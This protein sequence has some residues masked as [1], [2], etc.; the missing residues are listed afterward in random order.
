LLKN[1]PDDFWA[2]L[3]E[4]GLQQEYAAGET[5]VKAGDTT[6]DVYLILSGQLRVSRLSRGGREPNLADLG[7][8][9]IFGELAAIDGQP[10]SAMV[11]ALT[12]ATIVK[13]SANAFRDTLF[14]NNEWVW[15]LLK[16]LSARSRNL[17]ERTFEFATL[18]VHGRVISEIARLSGLTG[19]EQEV[20]DL[21]NFP[22]HE[23]LAARIGAQRE[24]VTRSLRALTKAGIINQQRRN[25]KVLSSQKLAQALINE[26]GEWPDV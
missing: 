18:S 11:S 12:N 6:T 13:V 15:W 5:L 22:T 8:R 9:D 1:I 25:L 4:T 20:L 21:Q 26:G 10:R 7:K 19:R 16:S 24:A 17:T 14:K 23:E 2:A 3:I